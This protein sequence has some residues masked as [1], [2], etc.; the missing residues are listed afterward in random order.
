MIPAG[1]GKASLASAG[2]GNAAAT[3]GSSTITALPAAY[4][5]AYLLREAR[6]KSY[7]GRISSPSAC[8]VTS[9]SLSDLSIVASLT[10]G[11][12][13]RADD[14]NRAAGLHNMIAQ[15]RSGRFVPTLRASQAPEERKTVAHGVN[16][17]EIRR[18][19]PA[20]ER[21]GTVLAEMSFAPFRG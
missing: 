2:F 4:R 15:R 11:C 10:T 13:P 17:G 12:Q 1:A 9:R 18:Q 3:S 21:G 19:V 7:S 5:D 8:L 16:R 14:P 20:P 6:L